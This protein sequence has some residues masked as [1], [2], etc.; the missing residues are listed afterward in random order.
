MMIK[1]LGVGALAAGMLV[2][3]AAAFAD[4]AVVGATPL[5][6]PVK[7]PALAQPVGL[8]PIAT[9]LGA[10]MTQVRW[11][12]PLGTEGGHYVAS[13]P[14]QPRLAPARGAEGAHYDYTATR[15][16]R[17][18]PPRGTEG[19]HF[20]GTCSPQPRWVP[21]HGPRG[22]HYVYAGPFTSESSTRPIATSTTA[23]AA[24]SWDFDW[25]SAGI[26]AATVL[27][28]LAIALAA[29]S[30]LRARSIARPRTP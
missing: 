30:G 14:A 3:P 6:G 21:A 9:P 24:P 15:C 5:V 4:S 20:V 8:G 23:S 1:N 19:G 13:C 10:C 16:V 12:K 29:T 11:V 28:A 2:V 18:V 17:W 7:Q 25:E 22:G 26:G 27:A